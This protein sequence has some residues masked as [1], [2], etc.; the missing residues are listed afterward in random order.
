MKL[1]PGQARIA[2]Q[3]LEGRLMKMK[4]EIN[5][6]ARGEKGQALM[7]TLILLLLGSLITV[8]VLA[9]TST[10]L[11]TGEVYEEDLLELYAADAGIEDAIQQ[12]ITGAEGLPTETNPTWSYQLADVNGKQVDI[13]ITYLDDAAYKITSTA[14]NTQ[15]TVFI[16]P[17]FGDYGGILDN[18]ITSQGEYTLQGPTTVDPPEGEEHGPVENYEGDWPTPEQLILYYSR[19]VEGVTPY[20]SG[21]LD[22]DDYAGTGIGPLYRDGT[23]SIV[24][25][26][27]A[28]LTVTLNG[29]LYITGNTQ[30]GTTGHDFTLNLNGQ[31]IFVE[32]DD[33]SGYALQIGTKCNLVGTG[34]IIAIGS[35]QFKPN[36]SS[37]PS[38][39]LLVMSVLGMTYM[40]PNGDFY[41][42]LAG[43]AEVWIQ[44]GSAHWSEPG[45]GGINFPGE[46]GE[47]EEGT[48]YLIHS[49]EIGQP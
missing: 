46:G 40:Q 48:E 17:L 10:G 35:I 23:L 22:V 29:T 45:G 2:K 42:T 28:G 31:T 43:S 44:N 18:V 11:D 8:P 24:N 25:S 14:G 49:W 27:S 37:G 3:K 33:I 7:I 47:G 5:K 38:D 21:T 1:S 34:C 4:I 19:D 26:G 32:S 15:I 9:F 36:L 12:I 13:T 41:G 6:I 39:Y 30:I 20:P 16:A